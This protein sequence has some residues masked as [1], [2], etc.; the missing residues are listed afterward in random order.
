MEKQNHHK[1]ANLS[2][3]IFTLE[4]DET[5]S[6]MLSYEKIKMGCFLISQVIKEG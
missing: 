6:N 3:T 1:K 2:G 4:I 5:H